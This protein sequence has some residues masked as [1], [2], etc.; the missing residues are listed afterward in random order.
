MGVPIGV[1]VTVASNI[2]HFW[3]GGGLKI[4]F[5]VVK[6]KKIVP[7]INVDPGDH[8]FRICYNFRQFWQIKIL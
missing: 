4:H 2:Y 1:K 5:S 8:P 3:L 7:L 6:G